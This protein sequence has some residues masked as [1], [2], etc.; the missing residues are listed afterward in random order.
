M[1]FSTFTTHTYKDE[2]KNH[3]APLI[4]EITQK[5]IR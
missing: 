3:S 1:E 5:K 4:K 2:Y